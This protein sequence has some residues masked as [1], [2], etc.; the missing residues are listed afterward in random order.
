MDETARNVHNRKEAMKN[1]FLDNGWP[2]NFKV[3]EFRMAQKSWQDKTPQLNAARLGLRKASYGEASEEFSY[4]EP[5]ENLTRA[6]QKYSK[7]L[8]ERQPEPLQLFGPKGVI[9]RP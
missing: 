8:E 6:I 7:F 5:S 3:K 4:G 9:A 1:L 2:N